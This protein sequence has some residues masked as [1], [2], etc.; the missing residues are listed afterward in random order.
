MRA[1]SAIPAFAPIERPP[2]VWAKASMVVLL[3]GVELAFGV[4]EMVVV[5]LGRI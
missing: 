5:R 3:V 1:A 4:A 2:F